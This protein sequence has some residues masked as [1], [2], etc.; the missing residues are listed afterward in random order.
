MASSCFQICTAHQSEPK[1]PNSTKSTM[2]RA[3]VQLYLVPP[4]WRESRIEM[5]AGMKTRMPSGSIR[6]I[7][8]SLPGS[9]LARVFES[10][11]KIVMK[12]PVMAPRG[13]LI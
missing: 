12:M 13:R 5:M 3:F 4:H 8:F 6:L 7:L 10:L 9:V 1:T 2:I 11:K